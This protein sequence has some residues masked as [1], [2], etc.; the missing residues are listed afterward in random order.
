LPLA[1]P[2]SGNQPVQRPDRTMRRSRVHLAE[3]LVPVAKMVASK[4]SRLVAPR[5]P[6]LQVQCRSYKNSKARA[7][8]PI[9][10][11]QT[12]RH[13][14]YPGDAPLLVLGRIILGIM[15][16]W[17]STM[18]F[19]VGT[20]KCRI[21]LKQKVF[22]SHLRLVI[23]RRNSMHCSLLSFL[24][25]GKDDFCRVTAVSGPYCT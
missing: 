9:D 13:S 19:V 7:C 11:C 17:Q 12:D 1:S 18:I 25:E 15:H 23:I 10:H 8:R 5:R 20:C 24:L 4:A 6:G 16:L 21:Y 22:Q 3:P 2:A 14:I